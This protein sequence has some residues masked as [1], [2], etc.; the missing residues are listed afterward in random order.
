MQWENVQVEHEGRPKC[1]A[2]MVSKRRVIQAARLPA[3]EVGMGPQRNP[4]PPHFFAAAQ[5]LQAIRVRRQ[6]NPR[7]QSQKYVANDMSFHVRQPPLH[8]IVFEGP[9]LVIHPE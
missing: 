3:T 8:A 6:S 4:S 1:T 2:Q 9:P 5:I 7:V